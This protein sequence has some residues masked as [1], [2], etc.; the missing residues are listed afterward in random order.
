MSTTS[1]NHDTAL[2]G[3]IP[4]NE[5]Q[6]TGSDI[7]DDS[8]QD[9]IPRG[10]PERTNGSPPTSEKDSL[11]SRVVEN[12]MKVVF[13]GVILCSFLSVRR[14]NDRGPCDP[15]LTSFL[16]R[17][18]HPF[19]QDILASDSHHSYVVH[20]DPANAERNEN[21]L[22]KYT[23]SDEALTL[24]YLEWKSTQCSESLQLGTWTSELR[25]Q[26]VEWR[27]SKFWPFHEWLLI[28]VCAPEPHP[29]GSA[30][31]W[32]VVGFVRYL[33]CFSGNHFSVKEHAN[34]KIRKK[35]KKIRDTRFSNNYFAPA[36]DWYAPDIFKVVKRFDWRTGTK[37]HELTDE[38]PTEGLCSRTNDRVQFLNFQAL[39]TSETRCLDLFDVLCSLTFTSEGHSGVQS[40][41]T[42]EG[43]STQPEHSETNTSSSPY[44]LTRLLSL[45]EAYHRNPTITSL[46]EKAHQDGL[47][48]DHF[49]GHLYDAIRRT[50]G[51][52][53]RHEER[54]A[55]RKLK[56]EGDGFGKLVTKVFTGSRDETKHVSSK[57]HLS[58]SQSDEIIASIIS[59]ARSIHKTY[60]YE[61]V[62]KTQD[63]L[64]EGLVSD[65]FIQE[66]KE[67]ESRIRSIVRCARLLAKPE[68]RDGIGYL[69]EERT[70]ESRATSNVARDIWKQLEKEAE[71]RRSR[72]DA[73]YHEVA[74]HHVEEG[75]INFN[76]GHSKAK[77]LAEEA[78]RIEDCV[79]KI[80]CTLGYPY[81]WG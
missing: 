60:L 30:Q 51:R 18:R 53:Y 66:L 76:D 38:D 72:A 69:G 12:T 16:S 11:L 6:H 3:V 26:R 43:V 37:G 61:W 44:T 49:T 47:A 5:E 20:L 31:V 29:S 63:L 9:R 67:K 65:A 80:M 74:I 73:L 77:E 1:P 46:G 36:D 68:G 23:T 52:M 75:Y 8:G 64:D 14:Q 13:V 34:A 81:S 17:R 71:E 50:G 7:N 70:A 55:F 41:D 54:K 48:F 40:D 57:L 4:S 62:S 45:I 27:K 21:L 42:V 35:L 56:G 25:V 78:R 10:D 39:R 2:N 33:D 22:N 15:A 19:F 58:Q 32:R 24:K 79:K 59:K 28:S